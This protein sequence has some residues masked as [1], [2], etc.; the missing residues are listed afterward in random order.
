MGTSFRRLLPFA[1]LAFASAAS[2]QSRSSFAGLLLANT[3]ITHYNSLDYSNSAVGDPVFFDGSRSFDG[4]DR[5]GSPQTMTL[6]GTARASAQYGSLHVAVD[7]AELDN[8]YYN[9]NNPPLFDPE[10]DEPNGSPDV[11]DVDAQATFTDTLRYGGVAGS[12]YQARYVFHVD[13]TT[14]GSL[15]NTVLSVKI[16]NNDTE[17]FFVPETS[18]GYFSGDFATKDYAVDGSFAQSI[19]VSFDSYFYAVTDYLSDGET[20]TGSTD[21][22]STGRLTGILLYQNG[23]L[24]SNYTVTGTSGTHY[25]AAV[26]EP[27]P[28]TAL[29]LGAVAFLRRRRA[30]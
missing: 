3:P 12:G 8:S 6:R 30:V 17:N 11:L 13:G 18:S 15:M 22:S 29:G 1:L 2:A 23:N 16:A 26:P 25:P 28:L 20:F 7:H 21:F 14:Q 24:V 9:E 27:T 10:T 4:D 19:N 5:N